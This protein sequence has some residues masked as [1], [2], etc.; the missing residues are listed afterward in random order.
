MY[1][2]TYLIKGTN[3]FA[4]VYV[5]DKILNND[6]CGHILLIPGLISALGDHGLIINPIDKRPKVIKKRF[7]HDRQCTA[8]GTV[9]LKAHVENNIN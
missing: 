7:V 1:R 9:I 5:F 2:T 3:D 6:T 8:S 4:D